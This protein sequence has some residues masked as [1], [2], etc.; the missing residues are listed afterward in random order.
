MLHLRNVR[1]RSDLPERRRGTF[2][3]CHRL[4]PALAQARCPGAAWENQARVPAV[5]AVAGEGRREPTEER[6]GCQVALGCGCRRS[7]DNALKMA[8]EPGTGVI[9]LSRWRLCWEVTCRNTQDGGPGGDS[10]R[11]TQDGDS[12]Q[13]ITPHPS[14]DGGPGARVKLSFPRWR[15]ATHALW[16]RTKNGAAVEPLY[17]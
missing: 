16:G 4:P 3:A 1:R 5:A 13:A 14:Q 2:R 7:R 11:H 9:P 10:R 15:Q 17:S 12:L 6:G 8:A